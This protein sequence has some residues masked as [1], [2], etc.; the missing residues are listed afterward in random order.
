MKIYAGVIYVCMI[1]LGACGFN[2]RFANS[3]MTETQLI[4]TFWR[5]YALI[6]VGIFLAWYGLDSVLRKA[7]K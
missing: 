7:E 5:E 6:V 4:I 1:V 2:L 3:T